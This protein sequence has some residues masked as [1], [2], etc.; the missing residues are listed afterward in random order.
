MLLFA[1]RRRSSCRLWRR[2]QIRNKAPPKI[3]GRVS[4]VFDERSEAGEDAEVA[5]AQGYYLHDGYRICG[6]TTGKRTSSNLL[7]WADTEED[8][9]GLFGQTA[10]EAVQDEVGIDAGLQTGPMAT[11]LY[12]HPFPGTGRWRAFVLGV[13]KKKYC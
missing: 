6:V 12:R 8:E 2:K 11:M 3:I 1:F 10:E 13:V 5:G 9:D 4:P 7:A